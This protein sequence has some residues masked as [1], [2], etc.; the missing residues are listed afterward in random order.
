MVTHA[1][2][3]DDGD[4]LCGFSEHKLA[5]EFSNPNDNDKPPTCKRCLP[6]WQKAKLG[7]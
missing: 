4:A 2:Y 7:L 1:R 6:K 3:Y 5:D